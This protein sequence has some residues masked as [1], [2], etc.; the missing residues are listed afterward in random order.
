MAGE[1][2][3][4]TRPIA[5]TCTIVNG[6]LT[7]WIT[8]YGTSDVT[9]DLDVEVVN[10]AGPNFTITK[11]PHTA[12]GGGPGDAAG[13]QPALSLPAGHYTSCIVTPAK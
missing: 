4:T 12:Y 1:L 13:F 5:A 2:T 7:V 3:P 6:N 10:T 8:N 9:L 11:V